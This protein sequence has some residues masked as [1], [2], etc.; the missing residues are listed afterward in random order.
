M[1]ESSNENWSNN[2]SAGAGSG[3]AQIPVIAFGFSLSIF[4]SITF[5]LCVIFG[6]FFPAA[7][8]YPA[9]APFLPG[10][11]WLSWPS[12][13]LGLVESFAYGWY[14][15]LIFIPLYNYFVARIRAG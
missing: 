9:W 1:S 2:Q 14:A 10:F 7:P 13:L 5:V 4:L 3:A 6:L 12:F 15:A 11:T 8:M